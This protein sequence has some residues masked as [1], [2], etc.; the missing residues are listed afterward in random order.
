MGGPRVAALLALTAILATA[1]GE[2]QGDTPTAPDVSARTQPAPPT[3]C[4]FTTVTSLTKTEF[5]A[6][7]TQAKLAGDMKSAGAQTALATSIGYQ[8]LGSIAGKY[9]G[10][11]TSTSN[12]SAL[13]VALL[14]CMNVGG[15]AVPDASVFDAA[16]G[17]NGAFGVKSSGDIGPV[18]SHDGEWLL[19]PPGKQPWS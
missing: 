5:G 18:T 12:A 15:A 11:Q 1:C 4:N 10:T 14:R 8:L 17:A 13:T 3:G 19:E 9:D 7:S 16:L 2:Q 6:G